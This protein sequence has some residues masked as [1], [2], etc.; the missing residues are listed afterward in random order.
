LD[1][2]YEDYE[3]FRFVGS[4]LWSKVHTLEGATNDFTAIKEMSIYLYNELHEISREFL[5]SPTVTD[6]HL[7]VIVITHYLPSFDLIADKYK[8]HEALNTFFA[9]CSDD[10]FAP[11]IRAW[12]YGHTHTGG[13]K[14]L[15][16]V[17]CVC[18]P[19]GYPG[20]YE[21]F[22]SAKVFEV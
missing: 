19:I 17:K 15:Y 9:S 18:N 5:G 1:N 20:E 10:L 22:P 11:T 8:T 4:T 14:E 13:A 21:E 2:S 7:P 3:G 16:G 12:V 6:S